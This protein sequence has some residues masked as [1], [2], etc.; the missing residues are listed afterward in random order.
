KPNTVLPRVISFGTTPG[1]FNPLATDD[2][3]FDPILR[4][5]TGGSPHK[6][7]A[8]P[9]WKLAIVG[10]KDTCDTRRAPRVILATPLAS[11]G[12][13]SFTI[14]DW[15]ASGAIRVRIRLCDCADCDQ[16]SGDR[17]CPFAG[18]EAGPSDGTCVDTDI[19]CTLAPATTGFA[20][21]PGPRNAQ[22]PGPAEAR[23]GPP[24]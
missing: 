4:G 13:I 2:D 22:P 19:P 21:D 1:K 17:D 3:W 24:P 15:M 23:G 14:P 10:K 8:I 5:P 20:P 16:L 18:R 6:Y 11:L 7:G 12:D 9:R